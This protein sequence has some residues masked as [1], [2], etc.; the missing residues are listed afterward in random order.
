MY[1]VIRGP[2][3]AFR[4]RATTYLSPSL[5][6]IIDIMRNYELNCQAFFLQKTTF[7]LKLMIKNPF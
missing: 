7:L 4:P 2:H 1:K 3:N 6:L 5:F